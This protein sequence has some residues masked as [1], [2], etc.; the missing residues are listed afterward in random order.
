MKIIVL[1][2]RRNVGMYSLSFLVSLGYEV[3][4]ITDD[5]NVKWLAEVLHCE[6]VTFDTMGEFGLFL[7][8]H[9]NK[10]IDEKYLKLGK[11]VNVHPCLFK[12]KGHNPIKRYI[13]NNDTEGS[14]ESHWMTK[15]VDEGEIIY[16]VRF[17]V[18][19]CKTYA[20]FYNEALRFYFL[21]IK[22][23]LDSIL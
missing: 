13:L 9:G 23:T 6:R 18:G 3:K 20:E 1:Y 12:Y 22:K 7:C 10:I 16:E 4:V 5:E 19:V 17:H 8:V 21:V 11:F 14:V 2:T 15:D